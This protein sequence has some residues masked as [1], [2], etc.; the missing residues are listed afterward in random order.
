MNHLWFNYFIYSCDHL[1]K[2]LFEFWQRTLISS[3]LL[4]RKAAVSC[5]RQLTQ[6][7]AKEVCEHAL[8]LANENRENNSVEG[9]YF[10]TYKIITLCVCVFNGY[11]L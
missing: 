6:R 3:H 11:I 2:Q 7:E 1:M 5:L 10:V 4:L 9:E 8:T